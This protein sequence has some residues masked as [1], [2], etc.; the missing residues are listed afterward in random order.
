MTC[1]VEN[2]AIE[3]RLSEHFYSSMH[4]HKYVHTYNTIKSFVSLFRSKRKMESRKIG[5]LI[6]ESVFALCII[7]VITATIEI[8]K[9]I[10]AG[11][12][13]TTQHVL[14]FNRESHVGRCTCCTYYIIHRYESH[15]TLSVVQR[16]R[17]ISRFAFRVSRKSTQICARRIPSP[18]KWD[19]WIMGRNGLKHN[20]SRMAGKIHRYVYVQGATESSARNV[21]TYN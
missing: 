11:P 13:N 5:A 19:M 2:R 6:F 12:D 17:D 20:L 4:I 10:G 9:F 8:D 14:S 3:L 1:I 18:P 7:T 16:D 21:N 15:E